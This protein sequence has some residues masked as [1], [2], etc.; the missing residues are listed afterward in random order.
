MEEGRGKREERRGERGEGKGILMLTQ[1]IG[2]ISLLLSQ[3]GF[4]D[5]CSWGNKFS[6]PRG[7]CSLRIVSRFF[8]AITA[9]QGQNVALS[10]PSRHSSFPY[11]VGPPLRLP[12]QLVNLSLGRDFN[13]PTTSLLSSRTCFIMD[14]WNTTPIDDKFDQHIYSLPPRLVRHPIS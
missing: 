8:Y 5:G 11:A 1:Q 6:S 9:T 14:T 7:I 3:R 4:A 2:E 10:T 13:P 12:L